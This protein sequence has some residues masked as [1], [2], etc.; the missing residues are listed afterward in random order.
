M[1]S[2]FGFQTD[3]GHSRTLRFEIDV[4]EGTAPLASRPYRITPILRKNV[5]HASI[6]VP[7]GRVYSAFNVSLEFT[8]RVRPQ[9]G[10]SSKDHSEL[11]N[12]IT[13][14]GELPLPRI[15]EGLAS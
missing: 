5:R 7:E 15:D 8:P 6:F 3:L 2:S 10:R 9:S 11:Q 13:K 14:V 1:P 12:R 4:L